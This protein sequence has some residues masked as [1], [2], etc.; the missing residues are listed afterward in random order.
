MKQINKIGKHAN[1]LHVQK[2][3]L[4]IQSELKPESESKEEK[5]SSI[6]NVVEETNKIIQVQLTGYQIDSIIRELQLEYD[7]AYN[8]LNAFIE[9]K[10]LTNTDII[11]ELYNHISLVSQ[12]IAKWNEIKN[13][14]E[15]NISVTISNNK[16]T[17]FEAINAFNLLEIK[18]NNFNKCINILTKE[19]QSN[20]DIQKL[21]TE[22]K[23]Q[24]RLLD[25]YKEAIRFGKM[26]NGTFEIDSI[27]LHHIK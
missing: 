10:A 20:F 23:K 2:Q 1:Q 15:S 6:T 26:Q 16:K 25:L 4:Q 19:V 12:K 9:T 3:K 8:R 5:I 17:L 7:I 21:F 27:L 13:I 14:F 24:E 11:I 22:Y 18:Q